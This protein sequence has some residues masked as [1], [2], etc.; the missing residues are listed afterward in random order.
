MSAGEPRAWRLS[1]DGVTLATYWPPS[2]YKHVSASVDACRW[3]EDER[4]KMRKLRALY[5]PLRFNPTRI[6]TVR[7][8]VRR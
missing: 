6:P 8:I 2:L 1:I 3:Y 5:E 4:A 7:E